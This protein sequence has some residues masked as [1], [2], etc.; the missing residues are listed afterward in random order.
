MLQT[1]LDPQS[2]LAGTLP[3]RLDLDRCALFLDLDGTLAN[4]EPTP[5]AVGPDSRRNTLIARLARRLDGRLAV[6]SGRT[7]AEIDR[8]LDAAAHCV[9][10]VHGLQRRTADAVRV[11]QPA[12][13][14]LDTADGMLTSFAASHRGLLLERK[15]GALALHYRGHPP[16]E[17]AC[18]ELAH[19]ISAAY[20][21]TVQEGQMVVELRTPGPDK[22]DAL[23]AFM[24]EPGFGG[25][26]PVMIGD[27]LTDEHA[28]IAADSLGG[29]G[30]LVGDA[31][32]TA[33]RYRLQDPDAVLAW[34][35]EAGR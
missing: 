3:P 6:L 11:D 20:G 17:E 4:I 24:A 23:L 7:I 29:F 25:M 10:G 33:A 13:P 21:L 2:P 30:I 32:P 34:L 14:M 8:I 31:R 5:D 19:R 28:F 9:A 15:P 16:A 1:E 12:H 26:V 27:D 22:G 35:E 18:L